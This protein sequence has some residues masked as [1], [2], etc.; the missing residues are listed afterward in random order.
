MTPDLERE[1]RELRA[2]WPD[3]PDVAAAVAGRLAAPPR[4]LGWPA[5][6]VAVALG[7]ALIAIVMAVPPARSA[8]LDWF[9]FGSV[10]IVREEPQP[11]RFGSGLALGEP[12]TLAQARRPAGFTP[13]VP[14]AVGPPDAVYV[15]R[16]RVDFVYRPRPGLPRSGTTGVGLLVTQFR[17]VATPL[18]E[19]TVGGGSRVERARVGGDPAFFISGAEH[20]FAYQPER[21]SY[22]AFEEQRLA[23]NTLVVDRRDGLLLRLEGELSRAEAVRIAASAR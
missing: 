23:G 2:P 21:S 16:G 3:T 15:S 14:A 12:V 8:I 5:W 7:A 17:A 6:Q 20:G 1:L 19:K 11:S 4:R 10:R 18:I 22:G 9:G 13:V